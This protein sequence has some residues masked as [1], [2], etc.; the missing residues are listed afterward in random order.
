MY[1]RD[2]D[3]FLRSEKILELENKLLKRRD[4]ERV[5]S[6]LIYSLIAGVS[7]VCGFMAA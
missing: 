7:F 1:D 3:G 2:D 6:F 4:E 5:G